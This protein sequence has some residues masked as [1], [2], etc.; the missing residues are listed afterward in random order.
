VAAA[1][2][3]RAGAGA[4]LAIVVIIAALAISKAMHVHFPTPGSSSCLVHGGK[5]D[6]PLDPAQASIAATI[7]GV[8]DHRSMP[9][10]AV[11]IAYAAALQ[12]SDLQNLPY[13]DR[14]SVGVFQQRPSAGW[15]SRRQLLN[16]VYASTRFFAALAAVPR[17][18]RLP[19]YR[20]AQAV[21]H[22]AD[23]RAY[24]QYA[25][26]GATMAGGFSGRQPHAV[27]CWYSAPIRG[28]GRLAAAEAELRSTFG[29]LAI[30]HVGDPLARVRVHT[31]AAGWAVASWLVS[32]ASSFKLRR[33]TYQGYEWTA[34]RGRKGWT[35]MPRSDR[36]SAARLGVTF[37]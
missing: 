10:R 9:A 13:G 25:Q 33:V 34:A 24:G 27:W 7:A 35:A 21:Q 2:S 31:V 22:S 11:A 14:D 19:I 30:R 16:P 6:V 18:L 29:R 4:V 26:Q 20:A 36:R 1:R 32:H 8:A 15:G 23:G 5:F 3:I 12:E 17:Y 37:G 28:H